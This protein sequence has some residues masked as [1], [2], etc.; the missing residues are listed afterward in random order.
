MRM[1]EQTVKNQT[2]PSNKYPQQPAASLLH[3]TPQQLP[4][5]AQPTQGWVHLTAAPREHRFHCCVLSRHILN[6]RAAGS[7][8]GL[9]DWRLY[10]SLSLLCGYTLRAHLVIPICSTATP[11]PHLFFAWTLRKGDGPAGPQRSLPT[12]TS[13]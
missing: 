9:D 11:Q 12:S 3:Q 10:P 7:P 8:R 13:E 6:M 4:E 2:F 5:G 1:G